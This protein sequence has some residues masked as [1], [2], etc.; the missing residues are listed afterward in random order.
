MFCLA[1]FL[2]GQESG[3]AYSDRVL[4]EEFWCELDPFVREADVY[5]LSKEEISRRLLE[6]AR[7]VFSG[8][9]Y[10]FSFSYTPLDRARGVK[11]E[12]YLSPHAEIPWGD[13]DLVVLDSGVQG[14]R[15]CA[16]IRY[17]V[18]LFQER[19]ISGWE[20]ATLPIV[21]GI[22][23]G[24]VSSGYTE[25][26]ASYRDAIREAVR[27]DQRLK[28]PNKPREIRGDVVLVSAPY[29]IVDAGTYT[30]RLQVKIRISEIVPYRIY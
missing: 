3:I 29:C 20:S 9:I 12:F 6:E 8:M 27:G 25:K 18:K 24:K 28:I 30:S 13:P 19:W 1:G 22:G 14:D 11:E 26:L 15:F 5:P 2:S 23:V 17:T 7:F 16:R 21:S 4:V 10:G